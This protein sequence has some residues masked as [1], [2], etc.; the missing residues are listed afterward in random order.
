MIL[1]LITLATVKTQLGIADGTYDASITAMI[2]IVS[3]DIRRI[4]N[5]NYDKYETAVITDTSNEMTVSQGAFPDYYFDPQSVFVMGQVVY[6]PALP[7]DTYIQ[8]LD[9]L[10]SIY[11]LSA[12]ATDDGTYLYPTLNIGQWPAVARPDSSHRK[13]FYPNVHPACHKR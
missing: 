9:P 3:N 2:P 4:L 7:E 10:T 1:N 13:S 12:T 6:S 8:S 5:T 11:T